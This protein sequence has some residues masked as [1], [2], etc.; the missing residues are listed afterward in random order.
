VKITPMDK[1]ALFRPPK[2]QSPLRY[3]NRNWCRRIKVN[4]KKAAT[5]SRSC[6]ATLGTASV[7]AVPAGHS[8]P[9]RTQLK[10]QEQHNKKN[11]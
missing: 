11:T 2:V 8:G 6:H 10:V 1:I 9:T 5:V 7:S 3:R 4:Y